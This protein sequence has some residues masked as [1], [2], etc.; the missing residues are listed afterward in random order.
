[1]K[2][3]CAAAIAMATAF[4]S[5]GAQAAAGDVIVRMRA[6]M[7]APNEG[8]RTGALST[9][10]AKVNNDVVPEVD[11]TYMLTNNIGAEL[12]AATSL[13]K[14]SSGGTTIGKSYVLPPTLTLQYHLAPESAIRPYVG[15]GFNYTIFYSEKS[16]GPIDGSDLALKDSIGFA[17]QVGVDIDLSKKFFLNLDLKYIDMKAKAKLNGAGIGKMDLNPLVFGIGFGTRF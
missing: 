11:F 5:T 4:L 17:G 15:V 2:K 1:M 10:G 12:I 14:I 8:S 6:I 7:V 16:K 9:L 13:H 3:T